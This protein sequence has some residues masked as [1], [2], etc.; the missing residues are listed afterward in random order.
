MALLTSN[1]TVLQ[2]NSETAVCPKQWNFQSDLELK[3]LQCNLVNGA[4]RFTAGNYGWS[5]SGS[6]IYDTGSGLT[7]AD[8]LA[9]L[10]SR[11]VKPFS[12]AFGTGA[13]SIT[14]TGTVFI[15]N[16]NIDAPDGGE[17][18]NV[19]FSYTGDDDFTVT[20]GS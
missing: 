18:V 16:V 10:K 19:S 9:H 2:I 11:V 8:L 3:D 15:N 6:F 20:A 17:V 12:G 4:K 7:A 5:G 14:I 13:G 1:N